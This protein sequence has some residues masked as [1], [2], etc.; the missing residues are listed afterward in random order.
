MKSKIFL[1]FFIVVFLLIIIFP[2]LSV[3]FSQTYYKNI[4]S[5]F[6]ISYQNIKGDSS[7]KVSYYEIDI[8]VLLNPNNIIA[9]TE[10]LIRRK[11]LNPVFF[12]N[13][14]NA[15][16][17]DSIKL[18]Q[19]II[20]FLH[21]NDK[22]FITPVS[23]DSVVNL[24]IFYHGLP[25]PTGFGSFIFSGY[26]NGPVIWSLSQPYGSQ[27]WFPCKNSIEDK[28]DSS[29]VRI[30][31]SENLVGVSNGVLENIVNN[32]N[33]TKSY[34]WKNTYPISVYLI[35]VA[36]SNYYEYKTYYKYSQTDSLLVVH[37]VYPS[38]FSNLKVQLDKTIGMLDFFTKIYSTYPFIKEKYGHAQVNF[39][40]GMEHQTITSLGVFMDNIIAHELAHQ[41]F[42]DK[43]TCKD[44]HHI[45]LNE[46][47]ATYSEALYLE[48]TLG[49]AGYDEF[50][51]SRMNF[52]KSAIGTIYVQ[53]VNSL[54]EIFNPYRSYAKGAI[55]LH[56]LRGVVGDSIF[57]NI[58]RSYVNDSNLVYNTA[59]TED[60]KNICERISGKDLGYFFSQWIYGENYPIYFISW[61]Y[62]YIS[63]NNY[64]VDINITQNLNNN[65][66]YFK[67]PLEI[68]IQTKD[69][70]TLFK[71]FNDTITCNYSFIVFG[72]PVKITLDPNDKVLK[73]KKGDEIYEKVKYYL[74]QNYPNPFNSKTKIEFEILHNSNVKLE[75]FDI[76]GRNVKTLVNEE[77]KQ[78]KYK[79]EFL[80]ENLPSGVY[81]YKITTE[82]FTDTKKM[83]FVQ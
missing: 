59:T 39:S 9:R 16:I 69:L 26:E 10:L 23:Q 32:G 66:L 17:V 35:S 55:V 1:I 70:D 43:I 63:N 42:G 54:Y 11:I 41:W 73:D 19:Q 29:K 27:D 4:N 21:N 3:S 52:A 2:A 80:P 40:G 61:N 64:K 50:I 67:M 53:D 51:R 33:G 20:S 24:S 58:L 34:F 31:C 38:Q 76:L 25:V 45:W 62:N 30:T 79:I 22:L 83:V 71:V 68:S 60:F 48:E 47:F 46:G 6:P 7:I 57:F 44:W 77:L 28:A 5:N 65:P 37:Y 18:N 72:E 75:V 49:K 78:G 14:S 74:G 12:L 8:N 56:M 13:L 15:L 81:F 82:H 36:L